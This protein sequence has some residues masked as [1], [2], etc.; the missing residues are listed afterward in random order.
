M[1]DPQHRNARSNRW[2]AIL[3]ASLLLHLVAF[4]WAEGRLGI[5]SW[6]DQP[7]NVVATA[8]INN[9]PTPIAPPPSV[10]A[11]PKPKAK[12]R[13]PVPPPPPLAQDTPTELTPVAAG[14][15][16]NVEAANDTAV[17][18]AAAADT[19][20]SPMAEAAA[21]EV[22]NPPSDAESMTRFKIN[23]PPSAELTY[24][25][26]AQ[27]GQQKWYGSGSFR[28]ESTGNSY[29][30]MGEANVTFLKITVL[31][32]KSEGMINDFGI[33]P[34]LYS[35]KPPRKSLTNTHFQ[36][37]QRKISF[38]ASEATYPYK[39]G[40]QDRGSIMW[41]LA[42]IG[43]GDPAQFQPGTEIDMVIA[44]TRKADTWRIQILGEEEI[45]TPY[46]KIAAWHVACAPRAGSYDRKFDIWLA[47]QQEWYPVK[48]RF[49]AV[50]GDY[51]DLALSKLAPMTN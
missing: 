19:A 3:L 40:E 14:Q 27:N 6:H 35:E 1:V 45:E 36:H 28:W 15:D 30:V 20:A 31:N 42:S 21:G 44:G 47:P 17:A 41:Q 48:V 26:F 22:I 2:I 5:P 13:R 16:S 37:E 8:L 4:N 10:A 50:N 9:A 51:V 38:S 29:R 24:D 33:A 46:G 11:K 23:P 34:V 49:T 39:G 43:R 25:V 18:D 7:P 32:F 12:P